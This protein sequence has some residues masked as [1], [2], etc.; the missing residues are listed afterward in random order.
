MTDAQPRK[1]KARAVTLALQLGVS[2]GLIAALVFVVDW[3][4][5]RQAAAALS[6]G[7]VVGVVALTFVALASLVWRW[8]ALLATVGVQEGFGRSWRNVFAGLFLNNFMP[9]PWASM[10]CASC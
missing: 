9:A 1:R 4:G 10:A 7:G 5:L 2:A 8:R 6:L 3:Q